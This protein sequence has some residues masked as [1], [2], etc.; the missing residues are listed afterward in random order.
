MHCLFQDRL[1]A[2]NCPLADPQWGHSQPL[3]ASEPRLS[4]DQWRGRKEPATDSPW[5]Q[6]L[7]NPWDLDNQEPAL[8][9]EGSVPD[10]VPEMDLATGAVLEPVCSRTSL[11]KT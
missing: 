8:D 9:R 4:K 11:R 1:P 5:D 3:A 7:G 10:L 2:D 6:A